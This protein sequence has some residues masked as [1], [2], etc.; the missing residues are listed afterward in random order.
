MVVGRNHLTT[1]TAN[2][3]IEVRFTTACGPF[4]LELH[5]DRH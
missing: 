2:R 1:A 3:A 5:L 4:L